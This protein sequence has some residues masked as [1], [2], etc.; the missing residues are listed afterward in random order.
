[1]AQGVSGRA[2]QILDEL[3]RLRHPTADWPGCLNDAQQCIRI[4]HIT[5]EGHYTE[6]CPRLNNWNGSDVHSL[7]ERPRRLTTL[8]KHNYA[9]K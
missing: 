7:P 6:V 9:A 4:G 1:M 2:S 3:R 8:D 5:S